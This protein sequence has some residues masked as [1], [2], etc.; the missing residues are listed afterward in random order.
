MCMGSM[1]DRGDK[2]HMVKLPSESWRCLCALILV[3]CR[4][5]DLSSTPLWIALKAS[6][7]ALGQCEGPIASH[8]SMSELNQSSRHLTTSSATWCSAKTM[9]HDFGDC[10]IASHAVAVSGTCS[11]P[12]HL[13]SSCV[14]ESRPSNVPSLRQ[15]NMP[16]ME[17]TWYACVV[18]NMPRFAKAW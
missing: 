18:A 6:D 2:L 11:M 15:H 1:N 13:E 12:P 7:F 14:P 9:S 17:T 8:I 3:L 4:S 5:R 16:A 10:R